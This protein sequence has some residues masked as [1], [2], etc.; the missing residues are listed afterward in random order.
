MKASI[1]LKD[2]IT[3]TEVVLQ[4]L[5]TSEMYCLACVNVFEDEQ[6][7]MSAFWKLN[8]KPVAFER[9][10]NFVFVV[11]LRFS[12]CHGR[13]ITAW[14][15]RPWP[16]SIRNHRRPAG[17]GRPILRGKKHSEKNYSNYVYR[18]GGHGWLK[19][20]ILCKCD[21][22]RVILLYKQGD[23]ALD[24]F[25]FDVVLISP[26]LHCNSIVQ[27]WV[28]TAAKLLLRFALSQTFCLLNHRRDPIFRF[29]SSQAHRAAFK[30]RLD[31]VLV[32]D[33]ILLAKLCVLN[34]FPDGNEW[35]KVLFMFA[36][37]NNN[38]VAILKSLLR[39]PKRRGDLFTV[40]ARCYVSLWKM[41]LTLQVTQSGV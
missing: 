29:F 25:L 24:S 39:R 32:L 27:G 20:V 16:T 21:H 2:E 22:S 40:H 14:C 26:L 8:R 23:S 19:Q 13:S 17:I 10:K 41:S 15:V 30:S 18:S 9:K 33:S 12:W 38:N 35:I 34:W 7:Y 11:V 3:L 31:V 28:A 5:V 4:S 37:C 36:T 1:L 6:P